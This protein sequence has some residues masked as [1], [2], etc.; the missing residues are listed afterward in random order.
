MRRGGECE[1]ERELLCD[2]FLNAVRRCAN[3]NKVTPTKVMQPS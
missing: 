3:L 1:R 2:L